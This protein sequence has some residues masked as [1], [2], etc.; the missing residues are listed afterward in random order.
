LVVLGI[1]AVLAACSGTATPPP[2]SGGGAS[3]AGPSAAGATEPPAAA[4]SDGYEG[5]LTTSGLYSATWTAGPG[6]AVNPFNSVESLTLASDKGTFGNV[7]VKADGSVSFGSAAPELSNDL[8]FVGTGAKVTLDSTG[9]FVCAFTIDSDL[10]GTRDG[11]VLHLA[12]SMTAHWHPSGVGGMS[13][14]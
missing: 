13:C 10:K 4:G 1:V 3:S 7:G 8:T 12:G 14:P 5:Q 6:T 11:A 2:Q 9:Q